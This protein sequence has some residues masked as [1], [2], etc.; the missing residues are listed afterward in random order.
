MKQKVVEP[1]FEHSLSNVW[2]SSVKQN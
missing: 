2:V 1:P